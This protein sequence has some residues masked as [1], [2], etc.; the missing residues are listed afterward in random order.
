MSKLKVGFAMCGS[1]CTFAKVI[2]QMQVLVDAGYEVVPVMSP[3]A[4]STDTR[5]GKAEDF[6]GQIEAICQNPIVHTIPQAEPFGPKKMV[7]AMIVA[8]CTGNTL[9]KLANG[10]TDTP[11]TLAVKSTLRNERPILIAV[12]T[13]DALSGSAAN[14][15]T[16]LNRKHFYFVPMRQ[17]DFVKKPTS[18]VADFTQILP[19]F[20]Q[21][22][23]GKQIQPILVRDDA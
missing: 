12:S 17:D 4:Y 20:E 5:F 19:A 1:F 16:L 8:P 13:N 15:G 3:I 14:I 22:L 7:D 6:R 23:L 2:P 11:V 9:G 18:I 10:I 21:A